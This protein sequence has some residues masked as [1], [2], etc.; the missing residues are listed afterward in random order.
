MQSLLKTSLKSDSLIASLIRKAPSSESN[1]NGSGLRKLDI[2]IQE[3]SKFG[4]SSTDALLECAS[5]LEVVR[6]NLMP[7]M[8][9]KSINSFSAQLPTSRS[10]VLSETCETLRRIYSWTPMV[11]SPRTRSAPSWGW[12]CLLARLEGFFD[13]T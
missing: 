13:R 9:S 7:D 6:L 10:L 11:L 5:T 1:D 12:R 4:G 2:R 8:S 3:S